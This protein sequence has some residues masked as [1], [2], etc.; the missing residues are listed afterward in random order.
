MS[1][2]YEELLSVASGL[3]KLCEDYQTDLAIQEPMTKLHNSAVAVGKAWS[4]SWMGYHAQVYYKDFLVPPL[5]EDFDSRQGIPDILEHHRRNGFNA[6][7]PN[8][9]WEVFTDR[10]VEARIQALAG[11]SDL[12]YAWSAE[13]KA[14]RVFEESRA[15]ALLILG[16]ALGE[17]DDPPLRGIRDEIQQSSVVSREEIL[18]RLAPSKKELRVGD[19]RAAD[20]GFQTP[21]H[22]RL[23]SDIDVIDETFIACG[24]LAGVVRRAGTHLERL[25][26][27]KKGSAIKSGKATRVFIGHGRSPAWRELKDF[28]ED[29][30]ALPIEEFNRVP[31][32]GTSNKERLSEMLDAS[33]LAF[34]IFTGEDDHS[35]GRSHARMNV[36]HEAGLFQGRHGF[37]R[38]IILLEEGCESFSNLDGLAYISFPKGRITAA[39]EEIRRVVER[40]GLVPTST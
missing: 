12:A 39:F 33:A 22:M 6:P 27:R 34:L 11:D 26:K 38:A 17:R 4:G 21:N 10:E 30:L 23:I 8:K 16:V 9:D 35:D 19:L 25:I 5:G 37:N 13:R 14:M 24:R 7:M 20:G 2:L 18:L 36:V 32:A 1:E 15:E 40:E 29:R 28:I 3:T 31:V